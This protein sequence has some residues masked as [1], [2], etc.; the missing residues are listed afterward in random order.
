VFDLKSPESRDRWALRANQHLRDWYAGVRLMKLPED[1]RVYEHLLWAMS[2]SA[3]VEVGTQFGASAL[4][5]RD[6][7]H[8]LARYG[9]ARDPLVITIDI[10]GDLARENLDVADPTWREEIVFLEADIRDPAVPRRVDE[11]LAGRR[12]VFVVEDSAHT[13]DTTIA[14]LTGL[15]HLVPPEGF[16]VVEDGHVDVDAMR[17]DPAWPRG[18][19]PALHDWL[20]TEQ[21]SV[22]AVR[23]D[24]ELYGYS[25]HP[26]GFLQ[27]TGGGA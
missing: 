2:A 4:W 12:D 25:G 20:E 26:E 16:F 6:R 7:L 18:V 22:F 24:L 17:L 15:A 3:V 5:F 10:D 9:R 23:R 8:A 19:L 1:L 13:Y 27:R 21:G 14:S 11:L